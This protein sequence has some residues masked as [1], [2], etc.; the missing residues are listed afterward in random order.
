MGCNCG[1][2]AKK[3]VAIDPLSGDCLI[4]NQHGVCTR[5]STPK[6]AMT[7]AANAGFPEAGVRR[8]TR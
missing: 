2:N 7:A 8:T 3:Y 5:F 1:A 4:S 6:A